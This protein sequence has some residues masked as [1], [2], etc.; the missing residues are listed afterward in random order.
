MVHLWIREGAC[1]TSVNP[2]CTGLANLTFL[3]DF[4][5]T[6]A[7][8]GGAVTHLHI[9]C[10]PVDLRVVLPKPTEPKYHLAL[11]QPYDCK[12]GSFG[13]ITESHDDINNVTNHTL[14][15]GRP[16][17]IVHRNSPC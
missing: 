10:G 9:T 15:I 6:S 7:T 16:I 4:I 13:V 2:H 8:S 5:L 1:P 11:P 17:H 3:C 12:L 14:L